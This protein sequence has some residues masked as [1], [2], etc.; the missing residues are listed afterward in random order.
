MLYRKY[1][2]EYLSEALNPQ[3]Y[4]RAERRAQNEA[5]EMRRGKLNNWIFEQLP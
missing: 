4:R 5:D 2:S 3:E 1:L